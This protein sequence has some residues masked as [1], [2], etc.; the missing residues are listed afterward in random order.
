M[1]NTS[2][3]TFSV[4]DSEITAEHR[5]F[6][7]CMTREL[8]TIFPV[9][10][11]GR[12]LAESISEGANEQIHII[13]DLMM[14][15]ESY[16]QD[17]QEICKN[18]FQKYYQAKES[19]ARFIYSNSAYITINLMDR[20]LLERT[21]DVRWWSL[22]KAFGQAVSLANEL[23]QHLM[24]SLGDR[25]AR[26][27]VDI[28]VG[29]AELAEVNPQQASDPQLNALIHNT[30]QACD[31]A[32]TR[33]GDIRRS[34]TLYRDLVITT[35][36]GTVI[37][38]ANPDTRESV[39]GQNVADETWYRK[40]MAT[41]DGN[42]YFA[43]DL[44]ESKLDAEPALIYSTAVRAES[45]VSGSV[46]GSMGVL[47]D[48]GGES[49]IILNEPLLKGESDCAVDGWHCFLT[50]EAGVVLQASDDVAFPVG[51]KAYLPKSHRRLKKGET[52]MSL[53]NVHGVDSAVFS[54]KTDGHAEYEGLGWT[55][56]L[57]VPKDYIYETHSNTIADGVD[58]NELHRS[59][60]LPEINR[61]THKK[62]SRDHQNITRISLNGI[63]FAT[64][65]GMGGRCLA[66]VFDHITKTGNKVGNMMEAFLDQMAKSELESNLVALEKFSD[67]AINIVDRNLFERA[68]DIRWWATDSYFWEAL[69]NTG[70]EAFKEACRRLR[71]IN[72][73][74]TMYRNLVLA[75]ANG[76]I[77]ACSDESQL[78]RVSAINVASMQWFSDAM[79]TGSSTQYAVQDVEQSALED[80]QDTS[81][82]YAG[83]VRAKGAPSGSA[84]GVL[85]ILFD[86]DTEAK[87][88]L[89]TCLPRDEAGE[90]IEGCAAFY[91]NA[92]MRIIETSNPELFPVGQVVDFSAEHLAGLKAERKCSGFY[93]AADVRYIVGS[94]VTHGYREYK[95]LG[96]S[97][98]VLR[99]Y[100]VEQNR[101]I[102]LTTEGAEA[103][104]MPE[105]HEMAF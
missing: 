103:L 101:T 55:A 83:G 68:A 4:F 71:V 105:L 41:K 96:W 97:A 46:I 12:S 45:E 13:G 88:I 85:G 29:R 91:T 90:V 102:D 61:T 79:A 77:V 2:K 65:M 59:L 50:N 23:Q 11:Q 62:L 48:F 33:L 22:E 63:I 43:Q 26:S 78:G 95:G 56:H 25:V 30:R 27:A 64:H 3:K 38:N 24:H 8:M 57:I 89:E 76:S 86:W 44:T 92:E 18:L 104:D 58:L 17:L 99:P 1:S 69:S 35:H 42:D 21:C 19:Y 100:L 47:F 52:Q 14:Q 75:D 40:A 93:D 9:C 82:I 67:Q 81:L 31:F 7:D 60:I 87:Q 80:G 51:S 70:P 36:D 32:C 10:S 16:G 28:L 84:I 98:H 53:V 6:Y 49:E 37:A 72:D 39:I 20:N 74:Y 54:A 5:E 73:S 66:P 15:A 34:Y 94:A